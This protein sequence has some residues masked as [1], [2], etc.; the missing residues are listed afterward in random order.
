[1]YL[2]VIDRYSM[3]NVCMLWHSHAH[4][5]TC[6]CVHVRDMN[7]HIIKIITAVYA[8]VISL[9]KAYLY[10]SGLLLSSYSLQDGAFQEISVA[11]L[12][13]VVLNGTSTTVAPRRHG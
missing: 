8:K 11:L 7:M 12:R 10:E 3:Y 9:T 2:P 13:R 1:M 6:T 4:V 5:Y